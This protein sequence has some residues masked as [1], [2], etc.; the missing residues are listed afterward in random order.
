MVD[1]LHFRL[2]IERLKATAVAMLHCN[3]RAKRLH[4]GSNF[5]GKIE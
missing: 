5:S 4:G 3:M 1:L 2:S